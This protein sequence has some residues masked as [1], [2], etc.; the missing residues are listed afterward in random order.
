MTRLLSAEEV[1][2]MLGMSVDWIYAETRAGR[3][4]HIK[5]GRY[6]RYRRESIEGWLHELEGAT[7]GRDN[8]K[9]PGAAGTA[10]GL[11]PKE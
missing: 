4:P 9:R 8:A 5:L 6:R 1:A 10:R 11:A 2:D 7:F 3:I